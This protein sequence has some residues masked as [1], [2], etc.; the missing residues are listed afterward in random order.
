MVQKIDR[1]KPR[2]WMSLKPRDEW[3]ETSGE[4]K[5]Y[6]DVMIEEGFGGLLGRSG[7]DDKDLP[8]MEVAFTMR[9]REKRAFVCFGSV[10]G[11]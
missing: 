7:E 6:R 2:S 8:S 4:S 11:K 10:C 9:E 1:E 5:Q 3:G